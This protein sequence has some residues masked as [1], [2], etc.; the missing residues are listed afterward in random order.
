MD[1]E[2]QR[3]NTAHIR[4]LAQQ[5]AKVQHLLQDLE[6]ALVGAG[7]KASLRLV[8]DLKR[9]WRG[10]RDQAIHRPVAEGPDAP[11]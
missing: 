9:A 2:G 10:F 8:G 1:D 3:E 4:T 5:A 11:Q 6:V 7:D